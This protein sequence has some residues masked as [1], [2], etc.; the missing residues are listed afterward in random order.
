MEKESVL[1]DNHWTMNAQL[2]ILENQEQMVFFFIVFFEAFFEAFF[3]E[4]FFW[5]FQG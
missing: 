4:I 1:Q 3:G 5:Y 2:L